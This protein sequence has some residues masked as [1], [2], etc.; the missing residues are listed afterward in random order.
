MF[1]AV[2]EAVDVPVDGRHGRLRHR[3]LRR[4]HQAGRRS[5]ACTASCRCARSTTGH[6]QAGHRGPLPSDRRRLR[7]AA[8]HL[9]HPGQHGP[10]G[11]R[12]S[13]SLRLAHE[14]PNIVGVKDAAGNP[15]RDGQVGC[16][17]H[18][19]TSRCYSGDDRLHPAAAGD[20]SGR[21]DRRG[22]PLDGA[23]P[24][25]DVRRLGSRRRGDGSR[26]VNQRMLESFA[27]ETGDLAPNPIPTKAMLR[28]HGWAVGQCRL[29]DGPAPDWVEPRAREVWANLEAARG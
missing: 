6:P 5:W 29:P 2:V 9:R 27:F 14:V 11:R 28:T 17:E 18:P 22:D 1:A 19:T 13:C 21:H 16:G 8:D 23:R 4:A 7:P 24:R 10:Q 26:P 15:C 20:R 12:P 3:P 25:R